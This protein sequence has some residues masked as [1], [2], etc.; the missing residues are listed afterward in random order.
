V[1]EKVVLAIQMLLTTYMHSYYCWVLR[2]AHPL[3]TY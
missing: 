2:G 3:S 1:C